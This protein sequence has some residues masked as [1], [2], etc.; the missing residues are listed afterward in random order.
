[1]W[2]V[3]VEKVSGRLSKCLIY[4]PLSLSNLSGRFWSRTVDMIDFYN[5]LKGYNAL[6]L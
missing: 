5:G 1:M 2:L 3:L 4:D 6:L